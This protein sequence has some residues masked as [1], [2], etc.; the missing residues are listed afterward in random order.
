[1]RWGLGT[2]G[3]SFGG[4]RVVRRAVSAWDIRSSPAAEADCTTYI[5]EVV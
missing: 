1:M 2:M 5:D 3:C 4:K